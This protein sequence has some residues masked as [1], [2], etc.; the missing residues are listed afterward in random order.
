[1]T[2][3]DVLNVAVCVVTIYWIVVY[4]VVAALRTVILLFV[5]DCWCWFPVCH[6]TLL[7]CP[8]LA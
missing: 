4:S 6:Y 3:N 2:F 1:M 5:V 8:L 7:Y